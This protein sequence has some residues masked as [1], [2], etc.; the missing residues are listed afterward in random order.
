MGLRAGWVV[1]VACALAGGTP[2]A[3][4]PAPYNPY[5]PDV[6][7]TF[8]P[9]MPPLPGPPPATT[10]DPTAP[11]APKNPATADPPARAEPGGT[12]ATGATPTADAKAPPAAP[13]E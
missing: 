13:T 10:A 5:P 1:A 6:F 8:T 3:A 11:P 7:P 4:Q 12:A 9:R 2:A